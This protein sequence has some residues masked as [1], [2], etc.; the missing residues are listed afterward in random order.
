MRNP[1]EKSCQMVKIY[2]TSAPSSA[3]ECCGR[4][5]NLSGSQPDKRNSSPV[6]RSSSNS[7]NHLKLINNQRRKHADH[8]SARP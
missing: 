2:Y 3:Q 4:S 1:E 5:T 8:Q 6:M 7:G